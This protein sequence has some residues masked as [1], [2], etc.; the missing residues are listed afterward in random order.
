MTNVQRSLTILSGT[1]L[2]ASQTTRKDEGWS[3]LGYSIPAVAPPA[4]LSMYGG[5]GS[6]GKEV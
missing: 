1:F 4:S 2:P 5:G 3:F 6:D